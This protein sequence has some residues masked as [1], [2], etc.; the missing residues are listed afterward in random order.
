MSLDFPQDRFRHGPGLRPDDGLDS[1]IELF[2]ID[3]REVRALSGV[4]VSANKVFT[5]SGDALLEPIVIDLDQD[6]ELEADFSAFVNFPTR[7]AF[8]ASGNLITDAEE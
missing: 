8:S 3:N 7:V 4:A 2:A 1:R 5:L 6:E